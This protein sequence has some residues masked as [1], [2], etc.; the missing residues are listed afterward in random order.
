MRWFS[1]TDRLTRL[2]T[3]RVRTAVARLAGESTRFAL[4]SLHRAGSARRVANVVDTFSV[5]ATTVDF[6]LLARLDAAADVDASH[7]ACD[8]PVLADAGEADAAGACAADDDGY[9]AE[10]VLRKRK[11]KMNKHKVRGSVPPPPLARR[12]PAP[13]WSGLGRPAAASTAARVPRFAR[14]LV[15]RHSA[16]ESLRRR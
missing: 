5:P 14:R 10:S 8:T 6:A 11:R 13:A 15:P 3:A 16:D 9:L 4:T 2:A 12:P 7:D 1:W